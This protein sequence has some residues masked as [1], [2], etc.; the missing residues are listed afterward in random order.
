M[1][2]YPSNTSSSQVPDDLRKIWTTQ[3]QLQK[4][5][6]ELEDVLS[7]RSNTPRLSQRE[8]ETK[9]KEIQYLRS[10]VSSLEQACEDQE[11]ALQN[12]RSHI[13]QQDVKLSQQAETIRVHSN[14]LSKFH[15][16]PSKFGPSPIRLPSQFMQ[17]HPNQ[18]PPPSFDLSQDINSPKF[19]PPP[20]P[21]R[22][23]ATPNPS[24]Q[25]AYRT[26][27]G[28]V[29]LEA[30]YLGPQNYA[31]HEDSFDNSPNERRSAAT[32]RGSPLPIAQMRSMSFRQQNSGPGSN[33]STPPRSQQPP[34]G[35]RNQQVSTPATSSGSSGVVLPSVPPRTP[36]RSVSVLSQPRSLKDAVIPYTGGPH[37]A[38]FVAEF[39]A[40]FDTVTR[41]AYDYVNYP[42]NSG[43]AAMPQDLKEKL[44]S[45]ATHTTAHRLMSDQKTR[46]CMVAK[47]MLTWMQINI[48]NEL[49]FA[50]GCDA[51]IDTAIRV[52]KSKLADDPPGPVRAVYKLDLSRQFTSLTKVPYYRDF[53]KGKINE[54]TTELFTRI[55][56]MMYQKQD[57]DFEGVYRL[58]Q[59]GHRI[60]EKLFQDRAEY[61]FYF[62]RAN[63]KFN[64]ASMLNTD[65][66][67][68]HMTSDDIAA[69]QGLVKLGHVP[70]VMSQLTDPKGHSFKRTLIKAAVLVRFPDNQ[71]R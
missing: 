1:P 53:L 62:P 63:E 54:R 2:Y 55:R 15:D 33:N 13:D 40:L 50:A 35:T 36:S 45:L 65:P 11:A 12:A 16:R 26:K 19:H 14:E 64:G 44:L 24:Q 61:R 5:Q 39:T 4:A 7:Q 29:Q 42:S 38:D 22:Q 3:E 56:P 17:S 41:F 21:N 20:P 30:P 68:S 18:G 58:V 23:L 67:Y 31:N 66:D 60:A 34:V 37:E 27:W 71:R 8:L 70:Q 43:D 32:G 51:D 69:Q 6:T 47:F 48:F 25:V 46:Y 59:E 9:D 57:G 10:L 52:I 49:C 28:P